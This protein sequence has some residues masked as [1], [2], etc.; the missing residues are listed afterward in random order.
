MIEKALVGKPRYYAWLALLGGCMAV[1]FI[2]WVWQYTYGLGI[3]GMSRDVT[4]GFYIAQFTF[5]VGVAASAV[6]VVLPYYLHDYKAFGKITVLGEF[7]AIPAVLLCM[8]FIFVDM[9]RPFHITNVFLY[10]TPWSMMFWDTCALSGYLLLNVVIGWKCLDCE[11]NGAPPPQ[12]IKPL[13][14]LSIPWAVSIHTVTAMLYSG[15]AARHFWMTAVLA[16]RFLASA[17]AAGP[18]LLIILVMIVRKVST[19]DAGS[20][21]IQKLAQI[22]T[23]AMILNV[24]LFGMEAFTAYYSGVP[25]HAVHFDYLLFGVDGH[26]SHQTLMMWGSL[27]M[28]AVALVMLVVPKYRRNEAL[29]PIT[30]VLVFLSI[31]IDKGAG[32]MT[33]GMIPSPLEHLTGYAPSV[34]EALIG[35]GVY[36]FGAFLLTVLYKIAITVKEET[37]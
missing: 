3:T 29:L 10:P 14:Y 30:C 16:P 34:P 9:G 31:W 24:F 27:A 5:L 23:Y 20:V 6:M 8:A 22:V 1:A 2:C 26:I 36:A 18:A 32:M 35:L 21:A 28:A 12:W 13:I 33:G 37:A 25:S 17:F 11:R 19:F 15:L 4:W 7:L